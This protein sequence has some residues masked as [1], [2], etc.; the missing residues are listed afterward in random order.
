MKGSESR[1]H[2]QEYSKLKMVFIVLWYIPQYD[3]PQR[4]FFHEKGRVR[5]PCLPY[6]WG[7]RL[8]NQN[9]RLYP[10]AL[11]QHEREDFL[12][13][14]R[15]C[16]W[17][18]WVRTAQRINRASTDIGLRKRKW[19]ELSVFRRDWVHKATEWC[20]SGVSESYVINGR[21]HPPTS[22]GVCKISSMPLIL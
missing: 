9:R 19:E 20:H 11:Y 6:S 12:T 4:K 21:E 14:R 3:K 15:Q 17:R 7:A 18:Y 13:V 16:V 2:R 8:Q 10:T 5:Y 22:N 1:E